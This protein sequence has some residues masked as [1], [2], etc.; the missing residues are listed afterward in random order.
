MVLALTVC[1]IAQALANPVT[2]L[3]I[4]ER[5]EP[6]FKAA[7]VGLKQ[8]GVQVSALFAGALLPGLAL[9]FGWRGAL[10]CLLLPALLLAVLGPRVAPAASARKP[11]SLRVARPTA[12]LAVLM[13]IQLCVGVVLSSFVTFLGVFAAGQGM[14]ATAIGGLIA[15][16]G[17]MGI[18]ARTLL[19]PLGARMADESWLLLVLL[20]LASVALVATAV[21]PMPSAPDHNSQ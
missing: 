18:V 1:G 21:R 13:S 20:L 7:V 16:F 11:L 10:A 9:G 15:G 14:S 12:R 4:A 6:A 5:V 19:T 17:V 2:N 3:L 8:S